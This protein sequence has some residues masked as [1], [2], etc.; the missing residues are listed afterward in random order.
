[1]PYARTVDQQFEQ[2]WAALCARRPD[3]TFVYGVLSTGVYCRCGCASRLPKRPNVRFFDSAEQA[4]A[5]GF[6]PCKR[7][8]PSD[9]PDSSSW[10]VQICAWLESEPD[11]TLAELSER[12]GFSR[13][14]LQKQFKRYTGLSPKRYALQVRRERLRSGLQAGASVT[15][16]QQDAGGLS[17][18]GLGMLAG[19]YRRG[20]QGERIAYQVAKCSLGPVVVGWTAAGVCAVELGDSAELSL[21]R[22][23]PA[24][25]LVEQVCPW[26]L[27][28][29]EALD[30]QGQTAQLPLDL[31]GT[32]FQKQVWQ[33]LATLPPGQTVSYGELAQLAGKPGAWR[34][35]AAA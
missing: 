32:L 14:H 7:C 18:R 4:A 3:P 28:V 26:L 24:A 8:R 16:A 9:P 25:E 15:R 22:R 21:R 29:L 12:S 35:G 13:F 34:A 31:R 11:L 6:R 23:F 20:G 5:A 1:M 27:L 10:L 17:P 2:R 33:T 30:S 19:R